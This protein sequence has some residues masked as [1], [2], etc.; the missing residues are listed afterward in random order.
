[1]HKFIDFQKELNEEQ[2][3][4]VMSPADIP[5]LVLAGAGSG[6]TRTLTYRV[7]NFVGE[8]GIRPQ[9]LL[10]LTFTNKASAQMLRRVEELTGVEAWKFWGGTFHGIGNKF[11]RME[12][13][14]IGL[15]SDFAIADAEDAEKLLKHC[16]EENMPKFFSSKNN[17][18][19]GLLKEILSYSRNTCQ[20]IEGAMSERFSWIETPPEQIERIANIYET[21]KRADNICDFD[22]LLELWHKLL[23]E[24]ESIRIRYQERFKNVLVDE[25][26]DTNTLQC[27]LL[28]LLC[29]K[30]NISAV[31]DDAQCIYSWRGANIDNILNFKARYPNG[32]IFKVE[33]NYRS[34]PQI[35]NFANQILDGYEAS[36][37]FKKTLLSTREESQKP[38]VLRVIDTS[39][40]ARVVADTIEEFSSGPFA[41]YKRSDIAVLYRA[42][43]QAMDLQLHLQYR[44]IPFAITSG[45]K[46]FEQAHVKDVISQMKFAANPRDFISFSRF[47]RFLPKI[48]DKTA[49]K[50]HD[51]A[52]EVSEKEACSLIEAL[53][54][55][56][57]LAKV[58]EQ[59]KP[60]FIPLAETLNALA[61]AIKA[62]KG[63]SH[64]GDLFAAAQNAQAPKD[65]VR[66]ACAD[67]YVN[68]MKTVYENWED[69]T[70]DFDALYEYAS[71][72]SDMD[73]F[74][75]SVSL[76]ISEG[77]KQDSATFGERVSLMTVHQAKGLEFPVVF[78]IGAAEG[79]FP[80]QRC[81]DD[82]D[83][84]EERR[85]FYVASTRAKDA[86]IITYPRISFGR[87]RS[88]MLEPSE[89]WYDIDLQ[90]YERNY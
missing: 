50:I 28:D 8:M 31:G 13:A 54:K 47:L 67:W 35:L 59:A 34:T 41:K 25:Y 5:A 53:S 26:Q 85:L 30:G 66:T 73:E 39:T 77:E 38:V 45:L 6:K 48:G 4:A 32:R 16:V 83:I 52:L 18:K 12:G 36:E 68:A 1:M 76:E 64:S 15:A 42:H 84:E 65:L 43:F 71:R 19:A 80:L 58:P 37:D 89:F 40:Q 90:L 17:P 14:A 62:A 56:E 51:K 24:N 70:Q 7:A 75:S 79:L 46:F 60:I 69:R 3:A 44:G 2:Y 57:V 88:E 29:A 78:V 10:L 22:D 63:K 86:L 23:L 11:L 9:E 81:I 87:G 74:L 33:Q 20:N 72:F 27:K 82:G 55:K 21:R 49:Q 61:G